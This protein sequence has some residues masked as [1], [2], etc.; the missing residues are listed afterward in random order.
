MIKQILGNLSSKGKGVLILSIIF[1]VLYA[2]TGT[3]MMLLVINMIEKI[4]SGQQVI[5]SHYWLGLIALVVFKAACNV[6][7]DMAKHF[8]GFDVEQNIRRSILKRLKGFSLGF[9]SKERIGEIST[10]IQKDVSTMEAVVAHMWSRMSSDFI[11]AIILGAGLFLVDWRMGLAMISLLPVAVLI[12][13]SGIKGGQKVQEESQDNLADMVSLF[14]EYVKGIPLLKAFNE[15]KDFQEKLQVST[16]SFGESSKKVSRRVA[17]YLGRYSFFVE[18]CFAVLATLGAWFVF[19]ESLSV[20]N[21]LIF[22]IISREFYKPFVEMETHWTNYIKVTDSYKRIMTIFDAP[23][24]ESPV[25][26]KNPDGFD[27]EYDHVGFSYEEGEFE[28]KD[29]NF[30]LAEGSLTALV[31]PSGSGK[32]TITNL[33]LRFWEPQRGA[34]RIGGVDIRDIN[35]D[36]LLANISIVMQNVILFAD[37]IEGNIKIGNQN[38]T[39]DDV[40][41]AAKKA[42]IH[43]FIMSLPM[44]YD[45]PVGENGVGL[46]GGQKQ[47]ISIA[48][49]FLKDSPIVLLDEITS[50][51]DPVNEAK[52][53][54]AISNLARNRTVLVIAHHLR[55]IRTADNI[56]V[57]NEGVLVEEGWHDM[58]AE[59]EGLYRK[60]WSAQEDARQ[61]LLAQGENS[62][63]EMP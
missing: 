33:L 40:I 32:T 38:A 47:R 36:D 9:Y 63:Q 24:V 13:V 16:K 27:I 31:G 54:R 51:V 52:I 4:T 5:L 21:Y 37:T 22:V 18:L 14:V 56:L 58:L 48:R 2:L 59:A 49:A 53:Q 20:F 35:Y 61:W 39:R 10:I 46:S 3:A 19:R 44:G 42:M 30:R 45:T 57:F 8:A 25:I 15:S 26:S 12:L 43:D 1:F 55:T 28:M 41:E 60:L 29:A 11:V 50:N 23:V 17:G 62:C 34:I 7:A 6:T